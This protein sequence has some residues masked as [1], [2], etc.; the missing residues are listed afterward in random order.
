[1]KTR[2]QVNY[3]QDLTTGESILLVDLDVASAFLISMI[4]LSTDKI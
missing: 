2:V 1:M 3:W 4:E